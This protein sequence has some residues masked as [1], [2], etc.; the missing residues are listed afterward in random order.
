MS[1]DAIPTVYRGVQFRSRLEA[2]WACVFDQLRWRWSYEPIDLEG[3]IPDFVIKAKNCDVLVE[4]KPFLRVSEPQVTEACNKI[5][6]TSW[7]YKEAVVVGATIENDGL[8]ARVGAFTSQWPVA[9]P[10][11]GYPLGAGHDEI[12]TSA[13]LTRC[14]ECAAWT[15]AREDGI[16]GCHNCSTHKGA[17]GN[18]DFPAVRPLWVAAGNAV[19]WRSPAR[20]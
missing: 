3:Y 6:R 2:R 13:A 16:W 10:V 17:T 20:C 18:P 11:V 1:H 4:V 19:Q 7:G 14:T 9:S 8:Q 12:D 15:F 5:K